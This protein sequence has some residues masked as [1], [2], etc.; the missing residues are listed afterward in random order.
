M[1][2]CKNAEDLRCNKHICIPCRLNKARSLHPLP[3][4]AVGSCVK[5]SPSAFP[6]LVKEM[7]RT[8]QSSR[9]PIVS[10]LPY[11][12]NKQQGVSSQANTCNK[13]CTFQWIVDMHWQRRS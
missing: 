12:C 5:A 3:L 1:N 8:S 11:F 6:F 10:F 9:Q 4:L 7:V 2:G 13:A